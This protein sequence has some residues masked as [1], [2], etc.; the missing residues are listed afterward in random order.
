MKAPD[1]TL[2]LSATR[3]RIPERSGSHLRMQKNLY[4]RDDAGSLHRQE[5]RMTSG[6]T[7][8]CGAGSSHSACT[9]ETHQDPSEKM[10]TTSQNIISGFHLEENKN[11]KYAAASFY[12]PALFH[13]IEARGTLF[14]IDHDTF[15]LAVMFQHGTLWVSRPMPHSS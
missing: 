9:G 10:K 8:R 14:Q 2:L 15:R 11:R 1:S 6:N 7:G 13:I 12:F 4:R 5:A 3:Q